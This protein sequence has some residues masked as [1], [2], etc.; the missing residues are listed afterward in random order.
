MADPA[1]PPPPAPDPHA[2]ALAWLARD[3]V[4]AGVLAGAPPLPLLTPTPDP[5]GTLV[6]SVVGQQLS[7]RAAAAIHA[8]VE[9]ALGEVTPE[10]LLSADPADLRALGLSWAKVRTV[11]ALAGA[12][13]EGRVDF[14]HLA[15]LPDEVVI[16]ALTPL[17]GIGRWTAEMF[18]M[19]GLARPDVF[20]FGDLILRQELA[21]LYPGRDHPVVVQ[22][23]SPQRTLAARVLWAESGR[24]RAAARSAA[25][26]GS[27]P[28]PSDPL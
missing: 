19:F 6:R 4:L 12:A 1:L 23:W 5:F 28:P 16:T 17:P 15:A 14:A 25:P 9:S 26:K 11:Q 13:R 21:R 27:R 22:A 8:R 3:P 2:P 24:R 10:R 18:L 20:S 7:V